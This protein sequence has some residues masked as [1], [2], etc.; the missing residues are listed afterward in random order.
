MTTKKEIF[1]QIKNEAGDS[2]F[3]YAYAFGYLIDGA[4]RYKQIPK[5]V[6]KKCLESL[7]ENKKLL[8]L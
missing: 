2:R 4:D 7:K 5:R 3:G 8:S 1:K 6:L